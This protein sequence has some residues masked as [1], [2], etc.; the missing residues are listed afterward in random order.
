MYE[1]FA[2]LHDLAT[3]VRY[4]LPADITAFTLDVL[5]TILSGIDL[6]VLDQADEIL[7][8]TSGG[9]DSQVAM[10]IAVAVGKALGIPVRGVHADLGDVEWEGTKA[11]A[12]EQGRVMGVEVVVVEKEGGT[13][14][15]RVGQPLS[16]GNRVGQPRPWPGPATRWCTS[17]HKRGPINK[18]I[19]SLSIQFKA[20]HGR[21]IRLIHIDGRRAQES[22]ARAKLATSE[23]RRRCQGAGKVVVDWLPIH[24]LTEDQVWKVINAGGTG[25]SHHAYDLG[26]PRLSCVFCIFAP[27]PALILAGHHNRALLRRYVEKEELIDFTF[28]QDL[29]LKEVEEAVERGEGADLQV[30]DGAWNM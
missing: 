21:P 22:T 16:K 6:D 26:M 24:T 2:S 29:S 4:Q 18:L 14:L 7:S 5:M 12:I 19:T 9:K 28:R 27:R 11:L 17:D 23:L 10:L 25:P 8:S 30:K 15:D 1:R 3:K 20:E 13:L